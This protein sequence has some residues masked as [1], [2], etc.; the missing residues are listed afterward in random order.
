[1][2]DP[3][4]PL[5]NGTD[6]TILNELVMRPL[7][8]QNRNPRVAVSLTA[9]TAGAILALVAIAMSVSAAEGVSAVRSAET[10]TRQMLTESSARVVVAAVSAVVRDF[11]GHGAIGHAA[12]IECAAV[13]TGQCDDAVGTAPGGDDARS[14][15]PPIAPRL[16]NIPPP[17]N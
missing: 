4:G 15:A 2:I 11:V 14:H 3:I 1:M 6:M 5:S 8:A 10:G 17:T 9:N 7:C 12:R 16:L 13:F